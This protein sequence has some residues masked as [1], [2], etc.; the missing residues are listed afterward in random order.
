MQAYVAVQK[1]LLVLIYTLWEKNEPFKSE[2]AAESLAVRTPSSKPSSNEELK[3]L[4]PVVFE[5]NRKGRTDSKKVAL[6]GRATQAAAARMN[7][8]AMSRL[9]LSF[10]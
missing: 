7:F 3:L 10:R 2:P 1:K 4:L 6:T 8:R 9:K 5:E